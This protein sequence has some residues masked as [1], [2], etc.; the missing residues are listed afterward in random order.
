MTI[1]NVREIRIEDDG[2]ITILCFYNREICVPEGCDIVIIDHET[3][4]II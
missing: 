4:G 1:R 3:V 2:K